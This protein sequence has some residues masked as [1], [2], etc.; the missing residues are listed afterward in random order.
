MRP[1]F[2]CYRKLL[3]PGEVPQH[4]I[5]SLEQQMAVVNQVV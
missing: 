3:D 2:T 1:T 4:C 5:L